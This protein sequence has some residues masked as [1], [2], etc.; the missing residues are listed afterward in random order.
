MKIMFGEINI[1]DVALAK[2][3]V[4]SGRNI[5]PGSMVYNENSDPSTL[6]TGVCWNRVR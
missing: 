5:V 4:L 2:R 1:E 6:E 3:G